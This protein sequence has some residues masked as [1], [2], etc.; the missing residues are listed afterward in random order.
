MAEQCETEKDEVSFSIKESCR[1]FPG[2]LMGR[3]PAV[4]KTRNNHF[5]SYADVVV[6]GLSSCAFCQMCCLSW[7]DCGVNGNVYI[8]NEQELDEVFGVV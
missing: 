4:G 8:T 5:N 7:S 2:G 1:R 6:K 3:L